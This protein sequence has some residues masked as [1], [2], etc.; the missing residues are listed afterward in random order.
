MLTTIP[1]QDQDPP[2][3]GHCLVTLCQTWALA[4]AVEKQTG[5]RLNELI[6]HSRCYG[7]ESHKNMQRIA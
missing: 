7:W 6:L 1:D 4:F 3:G 2:T 5:K